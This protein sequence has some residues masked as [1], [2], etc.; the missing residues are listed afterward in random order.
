FCA[1]SLLFWLA[2]FAYQYFVLSPGD[3][4][5]ALLRG[6]AF[7][8]VT[9]IGTALFLSAIFKWRPRLAKYWRLR[10]NFGVAGVASIT[11]HVLSV[12]NYIYQWNLFS[13]FYTFNP[14][15]NPVV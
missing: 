10:R 1:L 13:V 5:A 15:L 2:E 14:I 9:L 11:I 3:V 8:G 4:P 6:S 7:A 12:L